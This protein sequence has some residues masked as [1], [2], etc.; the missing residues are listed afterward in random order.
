MT[1][2]EYP[3]TILTLVNVNVNVKEYAIL[4]LIRGY[5]YD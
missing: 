5:C 4:T 2:V 1:Y 3:D